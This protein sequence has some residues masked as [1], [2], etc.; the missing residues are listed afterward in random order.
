MATE[1]ADQETDCGCGAGRRAKRGR[2]PMGATDE[3]EA[4]SEARYQSREMQV[5]CREKT[6]WSVAKNESVVLVDPRCN[7]KRG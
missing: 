4:E 1:N 3:R 6:W 2:E 5:A 7:G